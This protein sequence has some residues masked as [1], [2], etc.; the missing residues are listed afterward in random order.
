MLGR[1]RN[2]C[3]NWVFHQGL[4]RDVTVYINTVRA[5]IGLPPYQKSFFDAVVSPYLYLQGRFRHLN[6]PVVTC[7]PKCISLD[8]ICHSRLLLL[9]LPFG[10]TT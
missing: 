5:S 9:H 8:R 6:T 3:L 10:G 2:R 7:H 4:F 1:L